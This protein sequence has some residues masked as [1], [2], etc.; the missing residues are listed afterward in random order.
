MNKNKGYDVEERIRCPQG[1]E[2][3]DILLLYLLENCGGLYVSFDNYNWKVNWVETA[4]KNLR[5]PPY[6]ENIYLLPPEGLPTYNNFFLSIHKKESSIRL[7]DTYKESF[8]KSYLEEGFKQY[9]ELLKKTI[10]NLSDALKIN[11][12]ADPKYNFI[13]EINI[14]KKYINPMQNIIRQ[15]HYLH[16]PFDDAVDGMLKIK[17]RRVNEYIAEISRVNVNVPKFLDDLNKI[18]TPIDFINFDIESYIPAPAG[19]ASAAASAGNAMNST[20]GSKKI[21]MT[22]KKNK[23]NKTT[24]NKKKKLTRKMRK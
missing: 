13:E 11:P 22:Q 19:A 18:I 24:R 10:S 8:Y 4:K 3:D 16:I 15:A 7:K 20:G 6:R 2:A 9:F 12:P 17:T 14:F 5:D 21:K 1:T 23:K